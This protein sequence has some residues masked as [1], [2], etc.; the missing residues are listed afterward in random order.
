[1]DASQSL[2]KSQV[3]T[4]SQNLSMSRFGLFLNGYYCVC[5][6]FSKF[7]AIFNGYCAVAFCEYELGYA[8]FCISRVAVGFKPVPGNSY[9]QKNSIF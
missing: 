5:N 7:V 9:G 4:T 6:S 2:H 1:M 8:C 3:I